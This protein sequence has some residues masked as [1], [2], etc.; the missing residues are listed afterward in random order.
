MKYESCQPTVL[1]IVRPCRGSCSLAEARKDDQ[2]MSGGERS[3]WAFSA[4][5]GF[6]NERALPMNRIQKSPTF[7][8]QSKLNIKNHV[9]RGSL[10]TM[11]QTVLAKMGGA[12]MGGDCNIG[13]G[14]NRPSKTGLLIFSLKILADFPIHWFSK[15]Q[16]SQSSVIFQRLRRPFYRA[17]QVQAGRHVVVR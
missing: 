10:K 16:M 3:E 2:V 1:N 14:I 7:P 11:F 4:H 12:K 13:R 8:V 6:G 17:R 5:R 15:I 9:F